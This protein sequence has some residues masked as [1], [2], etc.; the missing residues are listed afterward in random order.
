MRHTPRSHRSTGKRFGDDVNTAVTEFRDALNQ[1]FSCMHAFNY[2]T[3]S[4]PMLGSRTK[5][6]VDPRNSRPTSSSSSQRR[7]D[8]GRSAAKPPVRS[9]RRP[10]AEMRAEEAARD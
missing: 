4:W 9:R 10:R 5:P 3:G 2:P 1:E 8:N 7:E 6:G